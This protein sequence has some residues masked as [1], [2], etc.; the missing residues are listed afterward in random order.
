VELTIV[1]PC[2][3]EAGHAEVCVEKA[4]RA[5]RDNGSREVIVADNGSTDGSQQI[6]VRAGAGDWCRWRSEGM[7][8]VDGWHQ[9]GTREVHS[10]GRC[11]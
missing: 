5:L 4:R 8:C 2:L 10:D 6:A 7:G 3:N 11:R 9:G 1:M